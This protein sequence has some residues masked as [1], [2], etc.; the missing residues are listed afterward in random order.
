MKLL[1]ISPEFPPFSLGGVS[2]HASQLADKLCKESTDN[3]IYIITLMNDES[4]SSVDIEENKNQIIIRVNIHDKIINKIDEEE[5]YTLQNK[6]VWDGIKDLLANNFFAGVELITIHGNFLAD[7]AQRFKQHLNVPIIYHAHTT[8]T[9]NVLESGREINSSV[10]A[11]A[12]YEL[13]Q[14]SEIIISVSDYLKSLFISYFS[15][16]VERIE[17]IGKGIDI[18]AYDSVLTQKSDKGYKLLYV[19]RLSQEKGIEVL[20]LALR[21]LIRKGYDVKL[22][23]VGAAINQEYLTHLK[24]T[25]SQ[26]QANP[27]IVFLGQKNQNEI[28]EYFKSSNL[29]IVPSHIETFGRVAIEAMAARVPVIVSDTGGLGP[30]VEDGVT[31]FKFTQGQYRELTQKIIEA[32]N[33][34]ELCESII[35]RAYQFVRDYY[36]LESIYQKTKHVYEEIYRYKS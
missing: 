19:G 11:T 10:I 31:G 35:D 2:V 18:D 25:I 3:L 20:I 8:Y 4:K 6:I 16:S 24:S 7:I 12:E 26:L 15:I 34:P 9:F 17:I 27:Y 22:Y 28:I 23:I 5:Q 32:I 14:Q 30:L 36:T 1:L 21:L 13:C 33:H 29:V